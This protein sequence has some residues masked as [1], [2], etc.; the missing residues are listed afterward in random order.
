MTI[1]DVLKREPA[2]ARHLR[3]SPWLHRAAAPRP[4]RLR[5]FGVRW[6]IVASTSRRLPAVLARSGAPEGGAYEDAAGGESDWTVTCWARKA[7]TTWLTVSKNA[8][9][10]NSLVTP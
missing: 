10:P 2:E 1:D 3:I 6:L 4:N 9:W 7:A 8:S 5:S